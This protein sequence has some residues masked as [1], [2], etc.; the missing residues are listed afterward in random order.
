MSREDKNE[1]RVDKVLDEIMRNQFSNDA[2]TLAIS[3]KS[4]YD[5]FLEV[6]FPEQMAKEMIMAMIAGMA[7][8]GAK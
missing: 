3:M 4:I 1:R 2:H 7:R 6:G 5:N 8:G